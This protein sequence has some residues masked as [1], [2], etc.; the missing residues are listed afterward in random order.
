M[1]EETPFQA[2][3]RLRIIADHIVH[4]FGRYGDL[5]APIGLPNDIAAIRLILDEL[6][7]LG[8]SDSGTNG[9]GT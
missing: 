9:E 8:P 2:A 6:D 4:R 3:K 1:T 5:V 7:G